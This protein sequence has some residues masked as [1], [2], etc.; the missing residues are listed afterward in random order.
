MMLRMMGI[1]PLHSLN[2]RRVSISD[3]I[4][5]YQDMLMHQGSAACEHLQQPP[6]GLQSV[7]FGGTGGLHV[8]SQGGDMQVQDYLANLV[9]ITSVSKQ[10]IC[11]GRTARRG[12]PA[13]HRAGRRTSPADDGFDTLCQHKA[14]RYVMAGDLLPGLRYDPTCVV[15]LS[16]THGFGLTSDSLA[17][18]LPLFC[19]LRRL[20]LSRNRLVSICRLG[21]EGM[22]HL[23]VLDVSSNLL[24]DH[25]SELGVLFDALPRL[26]ALMLRNNPCMR[27][28]A[29]RMRLMQSMQSLRTVSCTLR[30]LD[31]EIT[32]DERVQAWAQAT[33]CSPD[34]LE[35][36]KQQALLVLM[37]PPGV[38]LGHVE[39]LDLSARGL[40][41]V[42]GSLLSPYVSLRRLMLQDNAICSLAGAN[43]E[44]LTSLQVLDLRRNALWDATCLLRTVD[45]LSNLQQLGLAG[46]VWQCPTAAE[47]Q[48]TLAPA[49]D[50]DHGRNNS[51]KADELEVRGMVLQKLA[52]RYQE[53]ATYPLRFLDDWQ[54]PIQHIVDACG[55]DSAA[56][57]KLTF[58]LTVARQMQD[59]VTMCLLPPDSRLEQLVHLD[60]SDRELL[61]V[62]FSGMPLLESVFLQHN[63][64]DDDALANSALHKLTCLQH[65]DVSHNQIQNCD[66]VGE[67]I[68]AGHCAGCLHSVSLSHNPCFPSDDLYAHRVALL[69]STPVI[70]SLGRAG[71]TL[72]LLNGSPIS[73]AERVDAVEASLRKLHAAST[74]ARHVKGTNWGRSMILSSSHGAGSMLHRECELSVV[75]EQNIRDTVEDVRLTLQ[76]ELHRC[77]YGSTA[78]CLSN[79]HLGSLRALCDYIYL[80]DLDVRANE[81]RNLEPIA[82][83][84]RLARL[85]VRDNKV[86]STDE[87]LRALSQCDELR[88]LFL[89]RMSSDWSFFI[90]TAADQHPQSSIA[91]RDAA[92]TSFTREVFRRLPALSDCDGDLN[93]APFAAFQWTALLHMKRNF[94]VG[95]NS[96]ARIDL[97]DRNIQKQDFYPIRDWLAFLPV[98]DLNIDQNPLCISIQ[99]YRYVLINDVRTLQRLNGCIITDAERANAFKKVQEMK[100]D[101]TYN[102]PN[103]D[104]LKLDNVGRA[105]AKVASQ[106]GGASSAN[107]MSI[108]GSQ[109]ESWIAFVQVQSFIGS[110]PDVPWHSL[111]L[112]EDIRNALAPLVQNF[113]YVLPNVACICFW[114]YVKSAALIITPVIAWRIFK[115]SI[116]WERYEHQILHH[117]RP[118]LMSKMAQ[119]AVACTLALVIALGIDCID[120]SSFAATQDVLASTLGGA[121]TRKSGEQ[122]KLAAGG[123]DAST[124]EETGEMCSDFQDSGQCQAWK[125]LLTLQQWPRATMGWLVTLVSVNTL[126]L[127]LWLSVTLLARYKNRKGHDAGFMFS[128]TGMIKKCGMVLISMSYLPICNILLD[129]V[130]PYEIID[131]NSTKHKWGYSTGGCMV[132][133]GRANQ[134]CPDYPVGIDWMGQAQYIMF[135]VSFVFATVYMM[136]IPIYLVYHVREAVSVLDRNNPR[137][138]RLFQ[139]VLAAE[140][141][142]SWRDFWL[143]SVPQCLLPLVASDKDKE[144]EVK[145]K[146]LL[147]RANALYAEAVCDFDDAR[148]ALYCS[149][150]WNNK[151]FKI[152]AIG[153][154]VL[155][156]LLAFFLSDSSIKL[157]IGHENFDELNLQQLQLQ[158][159]LTAL[160]T[161]IFLAVSLFW[162]PFSDWQ[163]GL[164]DGMC[165][166]TNMCNAII[167][168]LASKPSIFFVYTPF[169]GP[170]SMRSC[171]NHYLTNSTVQQLGF[172][173]AGIHSDPASSDFNTTTTGN[174]LEDELARSSDEDASFCKFMRISGYS[175]GVL[176]IACFVLILVGLLISPVRWFLHN[177]RAKKAREDE[178]ELQ[179]KF[180]MNRRRSSILA[181]GKFRHEP[182]MQRYSM[183]LGS[184]SP[185]AHTIHKSNPVRASLTHR[186]SLAHSD[187]LPHARDS[188]VENYHRKVSFGG[189]QADHAGA[190]AVSRS[191]RV[192]LGVLSSNELAIRSG[193]KQREAGKSGNKGLSRSKSVVKAYQQFSDILIG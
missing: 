37:S 38:P 19:N 83:L 29:E 10:C 8:P 111:P 97:S 136:G 118:A 14:G 131:S 138:V 3:R 177:R 95:P 165:R 104:S 134:Q 2:G 9:L 123:V 171:S 18:A 24:R 35:L 75:D 54:I 124:R 99:S 32:I 103:V 187:A 28:R 161:A 64:L 11:R 152:V 153:E 58:G 101:L 163:D 69:A 20:N 63:R 179:E 55:L 158:K 80:V 127:L 154:R 39:E 61:H 31:S 59:C 162:Q 85:D 26:V 137:H 96:I 114:G 140:R 146:R 15:E 92:S 68:A 56:S 170:R 135:F 60:L 160:T 88:H 43:L 91:A 87:G 181:T 185:P 132:V 143:T 36:L 125:R 182:A 86:T 51:P 13:C 50:D 149:Y 142:R 117:F 5:A 4:H 150:K 169:H 62:D 112:Y 168:F 25:L 23:E 12:Q 155:I 89:E 186:Q 121:D 130:R 66:A 178:F 115:L 94:G 188:A 129:N 107:A 164:I 49:P 122:D 110:F 113:E 93:P 139:E 42:Q 116:D 33:T 74:S 192:S 183:N 157:W 145:R 17:K 173:L 45:A 67:I 144:E 47:F 105:Y 128:F 16:D 6:H 148:S 126:V 76:L 84:P 151:Y 193:C 21:L 34:K 167:V 156:L 174:E 175:L 22:M 147:V 109:I 52:S 48:P 176:N 90:A 40:R 44:Q 77:S 133:D 73:V 71:A 79:H 190:Y 120:C 180:A 70:A 72:N 65:L 27:T 1:N 7:E 191:S 53:D 166:L 82:S 189:K 98:T 46:N 78:L 108:W 30:Y 57:S 159:L 81:V 41:A 119:W 172:S 102:P 106:G 141:Q 184:A 100:H